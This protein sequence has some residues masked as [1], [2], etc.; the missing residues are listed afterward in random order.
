MIVKD[1][2]PILIV[3]DDI[4][5]REL[6]FSI[7]DS[8]FS[9]LTLAVDGDDGWVK[10]NEL[11]PAMVITDLQMPIMNGLEFIT[12]IRSVNEIV[13][14]IAVSS[15]QEMLTE[16][17]AVGANDVIEKPFSVECLSGLIQKHLNVD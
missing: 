15:A 4:H 16:A 1:N 11:A 12:S 9:D 5:F 7:L 3:D 6:M 14:I 17:L 13:P 8:L 2:R 10:F